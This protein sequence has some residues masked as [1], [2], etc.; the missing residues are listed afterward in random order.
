MKTIRTIL[1]VALLACSFLPACGPSPDEQAAT[2]TLAAADSF[3]T[4]TAQAPT[5]TVTNTPSPTVTATPAATAT[6]RPTSTIEPTATATRS[7]TPTALP[8][9]VPGMSVEQYLAESAKLTDE[10][11]WD[12]AMIAVEQ[13]IRMAPLS[14]DPYF[15]RKWLR[16][17]L[18]GLKNLFVLEQK[19]QQLDKSI[20]QNPSDPALYLERESQVPSHHSQRRAKEIK[21]SRPGIGSLG[22]ERSRGCGF[23]HKPGYES[24]YHRFGQIDKNRSEKRTGISLARS[25][26]PYASASILWF[27]ALWSQLELSFGRRSKTTVGQLK[28]IQNWRR[29]TT[30]SEQHIFIYIHSLE[31]GG[32]IPRKGR[33]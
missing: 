6:P 19:L 14:T 20:K 24:G 27:S 22:L 26:S 33:Q 2:A 13:A 8:T 21:K 4:L 17:N 7:P 12:E 31:P 18:E 25:G 3:A 29:R 32:L 5:A 9:L 10:G 15:R 28:A 30:I 16:T 1:L 11:K 23:N